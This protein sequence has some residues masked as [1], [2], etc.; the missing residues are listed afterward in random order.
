VKSGSW[1]TGWAGGASGSTAGGGGDSPSDSQPMPSLSPSNPWG[2][3][4][5]TGKLRMSAG[6]SG[7]SM[8]GAPGG[9]HR[10]GYDGSHSCSPAGGRSVVV[11]EATS[12]VVVVVGPGASWP[13]ATDGIA[14]ISAAAITTA[15]TADTRLSISPNPC[16][17]G[18]PFRPVRYRER[19]L[20]PTGSLRPLAYSRRPRVRWRGF[21][22]GAAC[23]QGSLNVESRRGAL[24]SLYLGVGSVGTGPHC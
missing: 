15:A 3:G 11:V 17:P 4:G 6:S 7:Q 19:T 23:W 8:S 1:V 2:S 18:D 12:T 20:A 10:V 5:S 22:G 9:M 16:P 24:R 13:P 21:P 14:T